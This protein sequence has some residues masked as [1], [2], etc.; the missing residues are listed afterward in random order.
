M[1]GRITAQPPSKASA[2][3]ASPP[4]APGR[5]TRLSRDC[6]DAGG[7]V[8]E[9]SPSFLSFSYNFLRSR[10][11]RLLS[12]LSILAL[13]LTVLLRCYSFCRIAQGHARMRSGPSRRIN[14]L[15]GYRRD[16]QTRAGS[17]SGFEG[18]GDHRTPFA[19]ASSIEEALGS[20]QGERIGNWLRWDLAALGN[21]RRGLIGANEGGNK[22]VKGGAG[23][24]L[25]VTM[26]CGAA[27]FSVGKQ[28]AG[29]RFAKH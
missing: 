17:F 21:E 9:R 5:K 18:R 11:R 4:N 14:K 27:N 3:P 8:A 7:S 22:V 13:L 29:E 20:A 10:V 15:A 28:L 26:L 1:C 2:P 25:V 24:N 12:L 19:S 6:E 16:A 23:A